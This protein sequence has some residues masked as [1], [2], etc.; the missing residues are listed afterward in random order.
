MYA[1]V[2]CALKDYSHMLLIN[3][4]TDLYHTLVVDILCSKLESAHKQTHRHMDATKC[5][6]SLIC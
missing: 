4:H 6:I 5:I 1:F 2:E 3:R